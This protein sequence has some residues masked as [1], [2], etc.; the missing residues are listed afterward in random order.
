MENS[1][2][3]SVQSIRSAFKFVPVKLVRGNKGG[4]P[5]IRE[6]SPLM[7]K[8]GSVARSVSTMRP[9]HVV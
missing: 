8:L 7:K 5:M 9:V 1:R 6:V 2:S 3:W 4:G